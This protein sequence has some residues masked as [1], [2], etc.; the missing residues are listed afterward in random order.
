MRFGS[1]FIDP[2]Q[3]YPKTRNLVY[4]KEG[5]LHMDFMKTENDPNAKTIEEEYMIWY[6]IDATKDIEDFDPKLRA[7]I[8]EQNKQWMKEQGIKFPSR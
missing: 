8:I 5:N 7:E 3:W 1:C 2:N 4:D 6:G